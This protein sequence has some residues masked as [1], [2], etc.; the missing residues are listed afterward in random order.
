MSVGRICKRCGNPIEEF[1]GARAW[2]CSSCA[3]KKD[4]GHIKWCQRFADARRR[5]S[6]RRKD[7]G[8]RL[9]PDRASVVYAV[10]VKWNDDCVVEWRGTVPPYL[11]FMHGQVV[12]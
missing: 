12:E 5:D 11:K 3:C 1:R 9:P 8:D 7:E 4:G 10:E 6:A 2:L